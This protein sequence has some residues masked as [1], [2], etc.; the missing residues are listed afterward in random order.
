MSKM[1]CIDIQLEDIKYIYI[2]ISLI[3]SNNFRNKVLNIN[4][5]VEKTFVLDSSSQSAVLLQLIGGR[6][7]SLMYVYPA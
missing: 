4:K 2:Y 6:G 5:T 1:Q 7:G 3:L